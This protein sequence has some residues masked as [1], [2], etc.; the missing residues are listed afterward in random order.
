MLIRYDPNR[1]AAGIPLTAAAWPHEGK[2]DTDCLRPLGRGD[3]PLPAALQTD[4][5]RSLGRGYDPLPAALQVQGLDEYPL[6]YGPV[7]YRPH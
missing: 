7:D 1:V 6:D 2:P 5:L 4:C 3:D